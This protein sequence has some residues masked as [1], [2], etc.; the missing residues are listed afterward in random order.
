MRRVR[1]RLDGRRFAFALGAITTVAG[2]GNAAYIEA[3]A[4]L[5][6]VLLQG[7]G[8]KALQGRAQGGAQLRGAIAG[9][10]WGGW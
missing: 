2:L 4:G 6:Q 8:G 10:G 7:L 1:R 5:A 9:G 3:K